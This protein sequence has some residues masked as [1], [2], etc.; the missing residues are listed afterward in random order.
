MGVHE[1]LNINVHLAIHGDCSPVH[2]FI[3]KI[4]Y[5]KKNYIT[6]LSILIIINSIAN[7]H[8]VTLNTSVELKLPPSIEHF[9]L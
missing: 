6:H 4:Q 5:L 9:K 1:K 7:R 8:I 3:Y 2:L